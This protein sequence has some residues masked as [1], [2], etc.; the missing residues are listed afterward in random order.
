MSWQNF[1]VGF[2][3]WIFYSKDFIVLTLKD[4][5]KWICK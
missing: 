1:V 3:S 2:Y 4:W 5:I